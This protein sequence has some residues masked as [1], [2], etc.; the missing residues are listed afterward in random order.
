MNGATTIRQWSGVLRK[1]A[2]GLACAAFLPGAPAADA[3]KRSRPRIGEEY[4]VLK[5]IVVP[6]L[7]GDAVR[8]EFAV[9]VM[10]EL[11]EF[12][13]R[14]DVVL[15]KP[16]LRDRLFRELLQMV[17]FRA[18]SARMPRLGV[19]KRRLFAAALDVVG[20]GLVKSLLIRQAYR[21]AL[22]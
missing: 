2:A 7:H 22:R 8:S 3:Q 6:V 11:A 5:P 21:R 17:T 12:D 15:L 18:R 13:K 10:L 16:R 9:V 14:I 4:V 19:L 1:L 20:P